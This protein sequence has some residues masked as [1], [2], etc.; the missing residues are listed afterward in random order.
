MSCLPTAYLDQLGHCELNTMKSREAVKIKRG[1]KS[2][3]SGYKYKYSAIGRSKS[4]ELRYFSESKER[5]GGKY[6]SRI[7]D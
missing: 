3:C 4:K 1:E 7:S 6:L 5:K 2:S